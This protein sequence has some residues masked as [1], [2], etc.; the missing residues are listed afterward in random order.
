ME[1]GGAA[2]DCVQDRGCGV[3]LLQESRASVLRRSCQ[4]I[5]NSAIRTR[6]QI[7][8]NR[9][10]CDGFFPCYSSIAYLW[11]ERLRTVED[12]ATR[13]IRIQA[14]MLKS[15]PMYLVRVSMRSHN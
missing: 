8:C 14:D 3:G 12:N 7:S 1:S 4:G 15:S 9:T 13:A 2:L 11:W 10:Y 5:L 6:R